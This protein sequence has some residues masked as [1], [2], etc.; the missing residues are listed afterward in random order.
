MTLAKLWPTI[1]AILTAVSPLIIDGVA[2]YAATHQVEFGGLISVLT[3]IANIM[4][5][6]LE[7]RPPRV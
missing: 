4:R 3:L 2:E 5:S 6:A 1:A 7:P